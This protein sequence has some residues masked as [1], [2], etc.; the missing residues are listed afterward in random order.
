MPTFKHPCPHCDKYIN[1]DVAVCPY[2]ATP[3]PFAPARCPNCRT[4]ITDL[5]WAAC[6]RC[7]Q[8]LKPAGLPQ[9]ANAAP[10]QPSPNQP[11]PSSYLNPNVPPP[12]PTAGPPTAAPPAASPHATAAAVGA[13]T[14][15][16]GCGAPLAPGARFCTVC[17]T[18]APM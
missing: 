9:P 15:C 5:A 17:G 1:R 11:P 16:S 10:I 4:E 13:T 6:P 8:S 12:P 2:C 3:D 18:L 14:N 7:G